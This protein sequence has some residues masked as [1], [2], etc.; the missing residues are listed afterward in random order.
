MEN[1]KIRK[2]STNKYTTQPYAAY[3]YKRY[4]IQEQFCSSGIRGLIHV[5]VITTCFFWGK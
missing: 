4:N 1:P 5:Q 3:I 2:C